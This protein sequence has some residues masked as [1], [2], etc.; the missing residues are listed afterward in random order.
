MLTARGIITE[1]EG[2]PVLEKIQKNTAETVLKMLKAEPNLIFRSVTYIDFLVAVEYEA[3][4]LTR[5]FIKKISF[6]YLFD[7]SL[8]EIKVRYFYKISLGSKRAEAILDSLDEKLKSQILSS[9]KKYI[10][11]IFKVTIL[12]EYA[13]NWFW[14]AVKTCQKRLKRYIRVAQIGDEICFAKKYFLDLEKGKINYAE[15]VFGEIDIDDE[16]YNGWSLYEGDTARYLIREYPWRNCTTFMEFDEQGR[17]YRMS[18][19]VDKSS[20]LVKSSIKRDGAIENFWEKTYKCIYVLT[21]AQNS[22]LLIIFAFL[23]KKNCFLVF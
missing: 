21:N 10:E 12:E 17:P 20:Q 19:C 15:L 14:P 9:G 11:F 3:P 18:Q 16:L 2:N 13:E 23:T 6:V 4:D 1:I 22:F 5:N 8:Q 7:D